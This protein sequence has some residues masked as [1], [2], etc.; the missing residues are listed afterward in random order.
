MDIILY[1]YRISRNCVLIVFLQ[2][3]MEFVSFVH[4][5]VFRRPQ[6]FIGIRHNIYERVFHQ[7]VSLEVQAPRALLIVKSGY[8]P[9]ENRHL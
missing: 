3:L 5:S 7:Y 6:M 8:R 9:Y 2:L 1:I 4:A